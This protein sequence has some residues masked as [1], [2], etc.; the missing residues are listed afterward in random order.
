VLPPRHLWEVVE[1]IVREE[2]SVDSTKQERSR[3]IPPAC[4]ESPEVTEGG[5]RPTVEAAFHRHRGCQ[6][7]GDERNRDTPEERN[8]EQIEQR[9][10]RTGSCDHVFEPEGS[11]GSVG[12]HHEDEVKESRLAKGGRVLDCAQGDDLPG[13]P[14]LYG[15][16]GIIDRNAIAK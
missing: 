11:A 14:N 15:Y 13:R 2:N 9:H 10:P 5:A 1:E 12:E 7:S 3:P 8:D 16:C 4:E 6:F